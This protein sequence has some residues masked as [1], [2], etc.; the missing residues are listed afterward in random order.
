[1]GTSLLSLVR[2]NANKQQI[3]ITTLL[4][5]LR[6]HPKQVIEYFIGKLNFNIVTVYNGGVSLNFLVTI[7]YIFGHGQPIHTIHTY[8]Y[9]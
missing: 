2:R 8:I 7:N 5:A 9:T 6:G 4:E 1:M 3:S